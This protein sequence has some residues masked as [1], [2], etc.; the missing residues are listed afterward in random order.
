MLQGFKKYILKFFLR[1]G[2][3]GIFIGSID[4]AAESKTTEQLK[5]KGR[6]GSYLIDV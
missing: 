1:V 4:A 6:M 2:R 3:N 5:N